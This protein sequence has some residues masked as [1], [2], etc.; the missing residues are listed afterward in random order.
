MMEPQMMRA[1]VVT[2]LIGL[3]MAGCAGEEPDGRDELTI[4]SHGGPVRDYVGLVDTLRSMGL[5]IQ[6][7]GTIRQPFFGPPASSLTVGDG[8]IQVFEFPDSNAARSAASRVDPDG[9]TVGTTMVSWV[10][11]PHFYRRGRLLVIYV[12]EEEAARAALRAVLGTPFAG[13]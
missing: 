6:P 12:G 9:R 4:V 3:A 13:G 2:G 1:F 8:Q 5:A 10:A 11:T 7:A